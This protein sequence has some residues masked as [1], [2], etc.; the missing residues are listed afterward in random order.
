MASWK[1]II[2][3]GSKASLNE[4]SASGGI[5]GTLDTAAQTNITSV[6]T[7]TSLAVDNITLDSNTITTTNSNGSLTITPNGTGDINLGGDTIKIGDQNA[8]ATLTTYGTGDL[9]LSTNEGTDSGTITIADAANGDITLAPNGSGKVVFSKADINGGAIDA[10]TIGANSATT[11]KFTTLVNDSSIAG[12]QLTGS[13]SG[14]FTGDGSSLTG[15]A[16]FLSMSADS[17]TADGVNLKT[18]T[19]RFAGG[20]GISTA[21]TDNSMSITLNST[22]ATVSSLRH[23][24]LIVGGN[25]QNN[26]IDFGTDDVILFDIDET[27]VARVDAAGVDVTGVITSTAEMKPSTFLLA[28]TYVSG[29]N[30]SGSG[31]LGVGAGANINGQLGTYTGADGT[32]RKIGMHVQNDISASGFK[33]EFFEITSSVLITS[34]STVFGNDVS[35]EHIFS[36]SI[37]VLGSTATA[38]FTNIANVS[39]SVFSGSYVGDGT[40]IDLSN[41]S[42]IGSE[43]FKTIAV[44]GQSN[45]VAQDNADTL[46]IASQS[47]GL[48]ITTSGETI[49][50]DLKDIP[51]A[52]LANS[53]I[54][55]KALGTNLDGLTVD[56]NGGLSLSGT[57]DGQAARTIKQDISDLTDGG[58]VIAIG[59]SFAFDDGGT[60]KKSTISQSVAPVVGLGLTQGVSG[61]ISASYGS[62]AG[63]AVQ[64][65]TQITFAGT[66]NEISID[67]GATQTLGSGGT[68]EIGL[69]DT[70]GGNRTFTGNVTIQGNTV[71]GNAASDTVTI[72]ADVASNIIPSADSTYTLGDD[73]NRFSNLFT[74]AATI[75]DDL[76]IGG[77][78][79]VNGTTTQIDVDTVKVEDNFILLNSG[80]SN[81][82]IDSGISIRQGDSNIQ[83]FFYD[84]DNTRFAIH[85]TTS[86]IAPNGTV[87]PKHYVGLVSASVSDPDGAP[88]YGNSVKR[89]EMCVTD[90]GDIWIYTD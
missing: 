23:N 42:T 39:A 12:S 81:T 25:S 4:V 15:I 32:T 88:E 16:A 41:N 30:I 17:G 82:A 66:S 56:T 77:N 44:A 47:D 90:G 10:T 11:G 20:N 86:E 22:I 64:G 53:T 71:I 46:T 6:G 14:S 18:D 3:S 26:Y 34:E 76:T 58:N 59:D 87:V 38:D 62:S 84:A 69:A 67:S 37:T 83:N 72:T 50:F 31:H 57:Y 85:K 68:V 61:H 21:V 36:G 8:N 78:L 60:T 35:D 45:V 52:S 43:I 89:G 9:I 29:S 1:K 27:E 65:N 80:S 24:S 13:F 19:L 79:V 70:I 55:G 49:T 63:T 74:D 7:L 33:G 73:S 2:T 54:S 51:N 75:T 40:N 28:G 5:L 48:L